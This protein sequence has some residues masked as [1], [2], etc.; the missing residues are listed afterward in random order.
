MIRSRASL[1]SYDVTIHVMDAGPRTGNACVAFESTLGC[2]CTEWV[3]VQHVRHLSSLLHR[4]DVHECIVVG[5]SV[6]G[7]LMR[8]YWRREL[9]TVAAMVL[10]DASHPDQHLRSSRQREGL[11]ALQAQ[12]RIARRRPASIPFNNRIAANPASR[13][14]GPTTL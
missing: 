13:T 14:S 2:P 12:L 4:M 9:S 1:C 3:I 6:G 10:V 7:L 11:R 5:H 8:S